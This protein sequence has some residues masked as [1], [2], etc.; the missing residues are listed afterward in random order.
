MIPPSP[1]FVVVLI[2]SMLT[3]NNAASVCG[4]GRRILTCMPDPPPT[5]GNSVQ[6]H[7]DD[8]AVL[9]SLLVF[10]LLGCLPVALTGSQK[11][12]ELGIVLVVLLLLLLLL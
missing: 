7:V 12:E 1:S 3:P 2:M 4:V 10:F 11:Q 5:I 8:V 6:V 9:V